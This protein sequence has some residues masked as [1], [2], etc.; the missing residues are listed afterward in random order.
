MESPRYA[1]AR[2][3]G[4]ARARGPSRGAPNRGSAGPNRIARAAPPF[5]AAVAGARAG[6]RRNARETRL[7]N[8]ARR[9]A[10][11][12]PPE[13]GST[14]GGRPARA[15]VSKRMNGFHMESTFRYGFRVLRAAA[16][17]ARCCRRRC[18]SARGGGGGGGGPQGRRAGGRV[19]PGE[20]ARR[21]A[22]RALARRAAEGRLVF[23]L[24]AGEEG[25]GRGGGDPRRF[26]AAGGCV[27]RLR[28]GA[29]L[30]RFGPDGRR[31]RQSA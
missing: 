30:G 1:R 15:N 5:I 6:A 23:G 7:R 3:R 13:T 8:V 25:G 28:A 10:R 27:G 20:V 22:R 18:H 16:R 24:C 26:A 31:P 4:S 14:R 9:F 29:G 19:S 11:P 21:W 17:R 2:T 12:K